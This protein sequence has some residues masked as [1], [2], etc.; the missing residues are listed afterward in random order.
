MMPFTKF[1]KEI[2]VTTLKE[3]KAVWNIFHNKTVF[4]NGV[5]VENGSFR[6]LAH[7]IAHVCGGDYLDYYCTPADE[8]I[9]KKISKKITVFSVLLTDDILF[10]QNYFLSNDDV[11]IIKNYFLK[12]HPNLIPT[13]DQFME[14]LVECLYNNNCPLTSGWRCAAIKI[15]DEKKEDTCDNCDRIE[16]YKQCIYVKR[17]YDLVDNNTMYLEGAETFYGRQIAQY[18]RDEM[19]ETGD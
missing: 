19:F 5:E 11:A 8:R 7:K 17:W 6:W 12:Y 18:I 14:P 9:V 3:G 15:I 16:G 1:L 4:Y 10:T 2:N 13:Y